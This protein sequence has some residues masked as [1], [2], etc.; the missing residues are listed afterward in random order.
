MSGDGD[1]MTKIALAQ[2]TSTSDFHANL[3]I[4]E[5]LVDE[6]AANGAA[7]LAFPEV[8]LYIGG[9]KRKLEIAETLD[10]EIVSRFR[11][12]AARHSMM[13]L[14]GSIHERISDD[15]SRVYNTAVLIA[16]DGNILASYRKLKL[17][18]VQLPHLEIK[19]S[20]TIAAGESDPPVVDT[21]IG[22]L[23]LTICFDLRFSD[24]YL[25]LRRHGAEIVFVPSN[26]TAPTGAAH[27]ETLLRAR[28]VEGQFFVAAPAQ[29]GQHNPKYTS[30]GHSMLVDP[31]GKV[32]ALAP[33]GPGLVYGDIDPAYIEKVRAEL[34]MGI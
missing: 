33:P 23:G 17:F 8:F 21:P 12:A 26:F 27:W 13:L 10:G 16:A 5:Q 2:T 11:E 22:K 1:T 25:Y 31:W 30:C 14:L 29:C 19:E 18:D 3:R 24:L 20:D 7:L 15:S 32:I 28:A 6:A 4:A 9:W 34:P